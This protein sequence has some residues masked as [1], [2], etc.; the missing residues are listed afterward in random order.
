MEE[1]PIEAFFDNL[2]HLYHAKLSPTGA[3]IGKYESSLKN[4]FNKPRNIPLDQNGNESA[5][6]ML[7]FAIL[8]ESVWLCLYLIIAFLIIFLIR[9]FLV[10]EYSNL[11]Y[12][13]LLPIANL[14]LCLSP[15]MI[16]AVLL[17]CEALGISSI[18]CSTE[19][20]LQVEESECMK[21]NASLQNAVNKASGISHGLCL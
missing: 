7:F 15:E 16:P 19:A 3:K 17:L 9:L 13:V 5:I 6:R 4:F 8:R 21:K 14:S 2:C 18:L 10:N 12:A 1:T 11:Y 20:T